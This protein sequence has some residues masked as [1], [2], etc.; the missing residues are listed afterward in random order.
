MTTHLIVVLYFKRALIKVVQWFY[1]NGMKASIDECHFLSNLD[2]AS[3]MAIENFTIQNSV[4]QK[5]LGVTIDKHLDFNKH[6]SNICKTT[7]LKITVLTRVF[8]YVTVN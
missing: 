5:L 8:P 6:V 2:I 3:T 1:N 7:S 4:S